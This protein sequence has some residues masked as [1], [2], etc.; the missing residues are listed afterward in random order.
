MNSFKTQGNAL[1]PKIDNILK[2]LNN[3]KKKI[4]IPGIE[5]DIESLQKKVSD[6]QVEFRQKCIEKQILPVPSLLPPIMEMDRFLQDNIKISVM[7][8]KMSKYKNR[9]FATDISA[10]K[11][12]FKDDIDDGTL[13]K[14]FNIFDKSGTSLRTGDGRM[15]PVEYSEMVTVLEKYKNLK[16]VNLM[17]TMNS[18]NNKTNNPIY[19][20]FIKLKGNSN[21]VL[22]E[23]RNRP[24][25]GILQYV[26]KL[27]TRNGKPLNNT[28]TFKPGALRTY[29]ATPLNK[30]RATRIMQN[31]VKYKQAVVEKAKI[32]LEK[33]ERRVVTGVAS[34]Q[35]PPLTKKQKDAR[36]KEEEKII[37][38][39]KQVYKDEFTK[40]KSSQKAARA[41]NRY[42]S[43]AMKTLK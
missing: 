34:K 22:V 2:K 3:N 10:L 1:I 27:S 14:F 19:N 9:K 23:H 37:L 31:K 4:N 35:P 21:N 38:V 40:S 36:R 5:K 16:L 11:K 17:V 32:E 25:L 8:E 29:L 42:V 30:T 20:R 41:Q 18:K 12:E 13:T 39:G 7:L 15:D 24:I 26:N 33:A 28:S 43:E 6:I